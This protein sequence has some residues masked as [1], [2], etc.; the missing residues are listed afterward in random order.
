[1]SVD[2]LMT[3]SGTDVLHGLYT[4]PKRTYNPTSNFMQ[5]ALQVSCK[6]VPTLHVK[7]RK[8]CPKQGGRLILSLRLALAP[9][10]SSMET[11]CIACSRCRNELELTVTVKRCSSTGVRKNANVLG[12]ALLLTCLSR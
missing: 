1:M 5:E 3:D 8:I 6:C 9:T 2:F 11:A 10:T 12:L 7:R 4:A